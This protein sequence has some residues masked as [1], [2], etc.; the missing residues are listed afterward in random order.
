[1]MGGKFSGGEISQEQYWENYNDGIG[2]FGPTTLMPQTI[3]NS[4]LGMSFIIDS[5]SLK[6]DVL[7]RFEAIGRA[8]EESGSQYGVSDGVA[9]DM[10]RVMPF[11]SG[12]DRHGYPEPFPAEV[13][14]DARNAD[15]GY[16]NIP[17]DWCKAVILDNRKLFIPEI[18]DAF[19]AVLAK[20][21]EVGVFTL[22]L[23]GS[24]LEK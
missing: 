19:D 20:C 3:W 13:V 14:F 22:S 21:K 18:K 8:F 1:M 16:Q 17:I 24:V 2:H 10:F 12:R 4:G 7:L 9:F 6:Q 11:L 15:G 23:D 5:G